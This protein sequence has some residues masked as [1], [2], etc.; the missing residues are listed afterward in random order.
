MPSLWQVTVLCESNN[1]AFAFL[2]AWLIFKACI[3][4]PDKT[5]I[6]MMSEM[7]ALL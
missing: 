7:G 6:L 3:V 5:S 1:V 2:F 4:L